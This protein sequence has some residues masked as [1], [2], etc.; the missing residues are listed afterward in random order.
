MLVRVRPRALRFAHARLV[1]VPAS[2]QTHGHYTYMQAA[3]WKSH[4]A[5]F[6]K[7]LPPQMRRVRFHET[8]RL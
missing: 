2:A 4:L 5:D 3:L 7:E 1:L 8:D 6:M